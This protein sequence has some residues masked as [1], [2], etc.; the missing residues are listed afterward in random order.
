VVNSMMYIAMLR[1]FGVRVDIEQ[2]TLVT[3]LS[4]P[5][6]SD[7]YSA[8]SF[9]VFLTCRVIKYTLGRVMKSE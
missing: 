5:T 4:P 3:F 1:R 8:Y 7:I 9:F 2:R 6:L